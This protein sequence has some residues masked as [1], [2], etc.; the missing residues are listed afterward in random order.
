MT[1]IRVTD[2]TADTAMA[3]AKVTENSRSR[4]PIIPLMKSRG[5]NAAIRKMLIERTVKL[6]WTAA[7]RAASNG[8]APL[9]RCL[10]IASTTTMAS[11][12]IKPVAMVSAISDRLSTL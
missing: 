5:V 2:T 3:T 12:T 6:I 8:V 4:R 1:G 11:S 9:S 7:F 10:L